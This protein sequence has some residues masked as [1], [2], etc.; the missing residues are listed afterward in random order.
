MVTRNRSIYAIFLGP[1][2]S[3]SRLAPP[4]TSM[5]DR[6]QNSVLYTYLYFT[7]TTLHTFFTGVGIESTIF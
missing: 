7:K 3:R 5:E 6:D 4:T 2:R 1:S